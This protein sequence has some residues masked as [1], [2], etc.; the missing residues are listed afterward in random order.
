MAA[1]ESKDALASFLG[2]GWSF[3]PEFVL[4][5]GEV[6]MSSDE[7]DIEES[8]R[9][10]FGTAIGERF[11][12]PRYGLDMRAL[13]FD[14]ISTTMRTFVKERITTALLIHEPRIDVVTLEVSSP[15]PGDGRLEVSLEYRVR[16]TNS[17]FNLVFPFYRFDSNEVRDRVAG[18]LG[19]AKR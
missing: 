9:I 1:D 19:G 16:A 14:P 6:R 2:T 8:L 13:L 3:P 15:D 12:V 5:T 18:R 4:E 17:R 7:R 11:L 10:L